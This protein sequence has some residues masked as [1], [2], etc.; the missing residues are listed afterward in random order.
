MYIFRDALWTVHCTIFCVTWGPWPAGGL[1]LKPRPPLPQ[2]NT[3][4]TSALSLVKM[5]PAALEP[6]HRGANVK[7][8][9]GIVHGYIDPGRSRCSSHCSTASD[10][11]ALS[12]L[13][14]LD[15]VEGGCHINATN[16]LSVPRCPSSESSVLIMYITV[17]NKGYFLP[18]ADRGRRGKASVVFKGPSSALGLNVL[19][20]PAEPLCKCFGFLFFFSTVSKK[21]NSAAIWMGLKN[22]KY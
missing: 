8:L 18:A 1:S 10:L 4:Q 3:T 15:R 22:T 13:Y 7:Y 6:R 21:K 14:S 9:I 5:N 11:T 19:A 16:P 2:S 17:P 12:F 20:V